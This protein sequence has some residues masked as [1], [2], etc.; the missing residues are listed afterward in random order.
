VGERAP[1]GVLRLLHGADRETEAVRD[2]LR[3]YMVDQCVRTLKVLGTLK[4]PPNVAFVK[5]ANIAHGHQQVNYGVPA[6]TA[7]AP[8]PPQSPQTVA[9][10]AGAET[11]PLYLGHPA[12]GKPKMRQTNY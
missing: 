6:E 4:N 2:D 5:Q 12:R 8:N 1:D 10:L 7:P 9:N 11:E 3:A